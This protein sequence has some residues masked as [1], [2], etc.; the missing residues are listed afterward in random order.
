MCS[1][2]HRK[3]FIF[4][5]TFNIL[6]LLAPLRHPWKIMWVQCS[7]TSCQSS[8]FEYWKLNAVF[9]WFCVCVGVFVRF[10]AGVHYI[11]TKTENSSYK[12]GKKS[13]IKT[14]LHRHKWSACNCYLLQE[15]HVFFLLRLWLRFIQFIQ[16]LLTK[17]AFLL[18]CCAG[19][20]RSVIL[21]KEND[22]D[23]FDIDEWW[24]EN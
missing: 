13:K 22:D 3:R 21:H 1:R 20:W 24:W 7:A 14:K 17:P 4:I 19:V 6:F 8:T 5:E 10:G 12:L 9:T 15:K 11:I 16:Q 23:D 2:T 18:A